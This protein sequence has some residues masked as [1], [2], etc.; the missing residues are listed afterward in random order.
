MRTLKE[1]SLKYNIPKTTLLKRIRKFSIIP[2]FSN[3]QIFL[4][5]DQENEINYEIERKK[6]TI[7]IF[8]KEYFDI[9]ESKINKL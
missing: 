1:L 5:E 3:G 9:Y 8:K 4:N 2:F 7:V 6:Y